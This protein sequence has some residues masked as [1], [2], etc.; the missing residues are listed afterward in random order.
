MLY[1]SNAIYADLNKVLRSEKRGAVQKYFPYLRLLFDAADALPKKSERLWRGLGVD[2]SGQY[3]E[4]SII[5]W[6]GVSSCTSDMNVARNF[7]NGC[8]SESSLLTIDTK[9]AVDISS[10][11][12][13][14]NEKESILLPGTQLKVKSVKKTGKTAEIHLEE[15]GRAVS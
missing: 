8:G 4:G 2:L 14:S 12:F 5:T 11:T 3:K 13:Y 15:V 6:W 7:A 9:T 1:T 10:I